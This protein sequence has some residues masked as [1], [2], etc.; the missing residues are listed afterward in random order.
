VVKRA[1][2]SMAS[3]YLY[4]GVCFLSNSIYCTNEWLRQVICDYDVDT[5]SL[6]EHSTA[7]TIFY[8]ASFTDRHWPHQTAGASDTV[9]NLVIG[10]IL[11]GTVVH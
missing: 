4:A 5:H 9:D 3:S 1:R 8:P 6:N 2:S 7:M 10:S 11:Y